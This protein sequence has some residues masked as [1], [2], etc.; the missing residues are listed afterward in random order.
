MSTLLERAGWEVTGS[1]DAR[2]TALAE[3][4]AQLGARGFA[5]SAFTCARSDHGPERQV[6]LD[7]WVLVVEE[8][9]DR[10]M[11]VLPLIDGIERDPDAETRWSAAHLLAATSDVRAAQALCRFAGDVDG[12]V[13]WQVAFGLPAMIRRGPG[14]PTPPTETLI[15]LTRDPD[16]HI[17]DWATFGL[18]VSTDLDGPT[19]RE[20]LRQR[21]SDQGGET[22]GEA[23]VG[24][25]RRRDPIA[26]PTVIARVAAGHVGNLVVMAA[27]ELADPTLCSALRDLRDSGWHD[28]S[29]PDLLDRA[30][31][32]CGCEAPP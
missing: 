16:A 11:D 28:A 3:V 6:G 23:L 24:L 5:E 26:A 14:E 18:G 4:R 25:A 32:A 30:L 20:A 31:R 2:F 1:F 21:L 13:R 15:A 29:F 17:R 10:L 9:P 12:D 22:A 8:D 7:G 27:E 19:I